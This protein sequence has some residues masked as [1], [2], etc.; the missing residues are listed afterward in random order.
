MMRSL[1]IRDCL[2]GEREGNDQLRF[3]KGFSG[4]FRRTS[5]V[6]LKGY[7]SSITVAA[8]DAGKGTVKAKSITLTGGSARGAASS[9]KSAR[10]LVERKGIWLGSKEPP[11][12]YKGRHQMK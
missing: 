7:P 10:L 1:T 3:G 4:R 11:I 5:T 12:S 8:L 6:V 2:L 9:T